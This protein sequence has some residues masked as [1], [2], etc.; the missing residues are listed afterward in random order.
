VNKTLAVALIA[1]GAVL[2]VLG[3]LQHQLIIRIHID[4]LAIIL[5]AVGLIAIVAGIFGFVMQGR[6]S[7]PA[8]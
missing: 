4:H 1:I 7:A 6:N 5:V 2:A 8:A 3:I